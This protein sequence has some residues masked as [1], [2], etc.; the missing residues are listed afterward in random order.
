MTRKN[1]KFVLDTKLFR[2]LEEN[3]DK[4]T[5]EE[6]LRLEKLEIAREE[7]LKKR[8]AAS[9][10]ELQTYGIL[11]DKDPKPTLVSDIHYHC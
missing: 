3:I 10:T 1:Q 8:R 9:R 11:R 2:Q 4:I 6:H 5:E 7:K